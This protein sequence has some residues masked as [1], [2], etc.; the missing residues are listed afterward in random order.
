MRARPASQPNF[1]FAGFCLGQ[2]E[3]SGIPYR[4]DVVEREM[5]YH[6]IWSNEKRSAAAIDSAS[7]TLGDW[8]SQGA[9]NLK[10]GKAD[11]A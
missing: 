6:A 10:T 9:A 7:E 8:F 2:G 5:Q 3:R 4:L 11:D 1:H